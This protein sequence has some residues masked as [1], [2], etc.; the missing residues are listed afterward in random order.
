MQ[1]FIARLTP[2]ILLGV[3]IVAFVFGMILMAYLFIFGALIGLA[4]F[5]IAWLR[6]KFFPAKTLVKSGRTYNHNDLK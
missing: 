4:I 5:A 6:S 2:F 3:A 1:S